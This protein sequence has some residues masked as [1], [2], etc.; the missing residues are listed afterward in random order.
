MQAI[1][2]QRLRRLATTYDR[3][4]STKPMLTKGLT[5][6]GLL[7]A[8]DALCQSMQRRQPN[9]TQSA[10]GSFDWHRVSRMFFWG[11]LF[12]GP[13]GHWWYLGLDRAVMLKGTHGIVAKIVAD[14]LLF[15]PPLTMLYFIWQHFLTSPADG[16]GAAL[17]FAAD[18]LIPTLKVNW[19]YWS[20]VHVLTFALVPL[21]YR[22]A[23][24]AVKNFFWGGYLS[25]AAS[26]DDSDAPVKAPAQEVRR[27]ARTATH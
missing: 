15:T 18:S 26:V 7:M 24:V 1:L 4:N 13:A 14:Q 6:G 3:L 27:L 10:D 11:A 23:F 17:R 8:G 5:C 22:V 16:I 25:Y 21:Q 20:A 19:V 12:N 9:K 2:R